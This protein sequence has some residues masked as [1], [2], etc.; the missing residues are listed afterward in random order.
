M[1][2]TTNLKLFKHDNPST[3]TNPFDVE[4]SLNEN[5]DKIDTAIGNIKENING[6]DTDISNL[7]SR[8]TDIETKVETIQNNVDDIEQEQTTQ[9][10]AI[11]A[12]TKSIKQNTT[13]IIKLQEEN[14]MLKAQIPKG[15]TSGEEVNLQDSAEMPLVDFSLQGNSK[16]NT[17]EGYNLL[18]PFESTVL[19][20]ITYTKNEDGT[21]TV[22]GTA[23]AGSFYRQNINLEEGDYYLSGSPT[24]GA[25]N[26]YY[27]QA[28]GYGEVGN[29]YGS[30]TTFKVT[31]SSSVGI[32]IM[33]YQGVT[34]NNLVFKPMIVKGTEKKDYEQ[35]GASPSLDY[36]SEVQAVGDSGNVEIVKENNDK[37]I[38]KNYTLPI[39][40]PLLQ[41]DYIDTLNKKEVHC[42][43]KE[44]RNNTNNFVVGKDDSYKTFQIQ[45]KDKIQNGNQYSEVLCNMFN[46]WDK[47]WKNTGCFVT[48]NGEFWIIIKFGDF[49]FTEDL[50]IEQAKQKFA[51]ILAE[52]SLVFYYTLTVAEELDLTEEQKQVLEQIVK[53]GTY[54]GV[55]HYY[56]TQNLKP[57]MEVKYYKDLETLLN[58]QEQLESTLN[59]VQAQILELG[60]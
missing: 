5:W 33:I 18:P 47:T 27:L 17:R 14:A 42:W 48:Y 3:N 54:K 19:N 43:K 35:Y 13:D 44:V 11:E 15:T 1:S 6:N 32:R 8:V 58:K 57:T 60:G 9:N 21:I 29:D 7:K 46:F 16:Q 39:Q 12:N 56:I 4:Q 2:E 53:D 38:T 50:T 59:N 36:P 49:G 10:K 34:V 30:G 22:N 45:F 25:N 23:S 26:T 31:T 51:D 52:T 28:M 20:G 41:E 55:T 37:S 24:G 40:K